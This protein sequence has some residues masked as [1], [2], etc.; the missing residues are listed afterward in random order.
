MTLR[1]LRLAAKKNHTQPLLERSTA[2]PRTYTSCTLSKTRFQIK[3]N[4]KKRLERTKM[5]P[6][7]VNTSICRP[8][9]SYAI[10]IRLVRVRFT[11]FQY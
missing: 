7:N 3:S 10:I 6:K 5:A 8:Q 1:D 2:F 9:L 11:L 4:W